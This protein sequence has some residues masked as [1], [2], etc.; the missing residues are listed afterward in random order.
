[1]DQTGKYRKTSVACTR[2]LQSNTSKKAVAVCHNDFS[3][4]NEGAYPQYSRV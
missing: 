3:L 2:L 4:N 1:M